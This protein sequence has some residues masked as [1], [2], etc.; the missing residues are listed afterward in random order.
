MITKVTQTIK[1]LGLVPP[2]AHI[3]VGVSGGADSMALLNVLLSLREELFIKSISVCH[4]NHLLRGDDSDSDEA[5]VA[6][7]CRK[8]GIDCHILRTDIKA[9][10]KKRGIS[11]EEAGRQ[12]RYAFFESHAGDLIATAHTLSDSAET[13]LFNL[14]RG[15]GLGGLCGIPVKRGN[16][17]RPLIHITRA[18][19]EEYCKKHE[20]P[21]V[22]DKTN[23][24]DK[25]SRNRIRNNVIPELTA[26][27]PAFLRTADSFTSLMA[28]ENDYL[29]SQ[30]DSLVKSADRG[31]GYDI[32]TLSGAHAAIRRRAIMTICGGTDHKRLS[33][34]EETVLSGRGAVMLS[35]HRIVKVQGGRLSVGDAIK[36]KSQ[37]APE[38]MH[39]LTLG[40]ENI[41]TPAGR[42]VIKKINCK[43][44]EKYNRNHLKNIL[45]CDMIKG[46]A[47]VRSR[48]PS[49]RIK[50]AGRGVGKSL[51]KLMNE[52]N[53]P[54]E[55]RGS[56]PVIA[57]DEGVIWVMGFGCDERVR[58]TEKTERA[59]RIFSF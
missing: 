58:V 40:D 45:D 38:F 53:I 13:L 16:I 44:L 24:D 57:D 35:P 30:S 23:L 28:D 34:I 15:T 8:R 46:T 54:P 56:I 18:E 20:I 29:I 11:T 9:A 50:Q 4:I 39:N 19:I 49:D 37:E 1:S 51:K 27:N 10:A 42:L 32:L 52:A 41:D 7:Y 31:D 48:H 47:A 43:L 3:T 59:I 33:L 36:E 12:E 55:H 2:G 5:F 25:Y 21:F 22:T 17:I 14:T 26:I 6:D